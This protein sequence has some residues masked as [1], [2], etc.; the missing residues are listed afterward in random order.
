[1]EKLVP[2]GAEQKSCD[3]TFD[4]SIFIKVA[5]SSSF[6]LVFSSTYAI[7]AIDAKASPLKPFVSRLNKSSA[8]EIFEVA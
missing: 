5:R 4:P 1:M 2:V 6:L 7:A 3:F 8:D